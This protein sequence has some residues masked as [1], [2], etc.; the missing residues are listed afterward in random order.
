MAKV[1]NDSKNPVVL[2]DGTLIAIGESAEVK[3]WTAIKKHHVVDAM[4]SDGSLK[5]DAAKEEA[6]EKEALIAQLKSLGID[7]GSNSKPE[8]LQKKLDE[9]LAAKELADV[10]AQLKDKGVEFT[11]S[12]SLEELKAKLTAAQ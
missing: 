9:A 6:G 10:A 2:P 8:T 4:L 12:E 1:T 11:E 3:G 7:A 5:A